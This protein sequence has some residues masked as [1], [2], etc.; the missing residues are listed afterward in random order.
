MMF[1]LEV[2][3]S[4]KEDINQLLTE[5]EDLM[6]GDKFLINLISNLKN[7]KGVLGLVKDLKEEG[8]FVFMQRKIDD[9]LEKYGYAG[10]VL[11]RCELVEEKEMLAI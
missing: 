2:Y 5:R 11:A 6:D 7:S 8:N 4:L 9:A 10:I 1:S 3:K